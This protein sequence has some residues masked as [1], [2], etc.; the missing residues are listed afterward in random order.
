MKGGDK[1]P[2]HFLLHYPRGS[3]ALMP[4]KSLR[5]D[6]SEGQD[7]GREHGDCS[8]FPNFFPNSLEISKEF[9]KVWKSLENFSKVLPL[10]TTIL[11]PL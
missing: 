8:F 5:I 7:A 10:T 9:G 4:F 11:M 2:R 3:P 1:R 6:E